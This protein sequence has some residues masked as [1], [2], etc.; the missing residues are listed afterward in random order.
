VITGA[1]RG[2]GRAHA[3]HLG[4]L[5][6]RLV[7]NDLG[8][9]DEGEGADPAV[10]EA[11]AR[12]VREAGGEA[13]TDASDVAAPGAAE[14]LV[15]RAIERFGR[16]HGVVSDAGVRREKSLTKMRAEDVD[17]VF[18][19]HVRASLELT[20]A[21]AAHMAR[22]PVGEPGG[23]IVLTTSS[24]AFFGA[25]RQTLA[26][27]AASAVVGM[28]RSAAVEL[29]KYGV[30]VNAIAPTAHT[31][32][33]E[34]SPLFQGISADSMRPEDVAPVVAFLLSDDA[35]DISGEVL[36]VAGARIYSL[37]SRETTGAFASERPVSLAELRA[38]WAQITRT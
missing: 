38:A 15:S 36:G 17:R 20:R 5:G 26:A 10:V 1:G 6:A 28:T 29:R 18:G 31:R 16:V 21:A 34:D 12:E 8:C 30:R 27:A 14:A 35:R 7:L 23:S 32:Q 37:Q 19:L 13:V 3:L 24:H 9:D 4:R 33:T 25:A 11:V 2:I 22:P